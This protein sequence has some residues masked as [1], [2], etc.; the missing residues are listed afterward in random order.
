MTRFLL[1]LCLCLAPAL[2]W[3]HGSTF[4]STDT[5]VI[6]IIDASGNVVNPGD[7]ASRSVRVNIVDA[8]GVTIGGCTATA[9]SPNYVE[10]SAGNPLSC[11]LT[12]ALR[13]DW[14]TLGSGE[15]QTNNLL[16]TSGGK[17]KQTTIVSG[18]VGDATGT[19]VEVPTGKKVFHATI[20]GAGA[21][22]QVIKLYGGTVVGMVAATSPLLC[23]INLN[24]TSGAAGTNDVC[25][26]DAPYSFILPVTS[27]STGTPTTSVIAMH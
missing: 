7:S 21:V 26:V 9:A 22:V 10:A 11:S 27:G 8:L 17:V 18:A 4:P 23:T 20:T 13:V 6:A 1:T 14:V 5:T 24:G 16:M 12:G 19:A 25:I 3:A 2:A 15:D